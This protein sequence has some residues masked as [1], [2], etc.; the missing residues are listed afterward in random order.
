MTSVQ[1]LAGMIGATIMLVLIVI[2]LAIYGYYQ[3]KK[4]RVA[5]ENFGMEV[6]DQLLKNAK[7]TQREYDDFVDRVKFEKVVKK[8]NENGSD[9]SFNKIK[10]M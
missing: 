6:M 10:D 1:I 4:E 7:I 9:V 2:G 3:S 5:D 8:A